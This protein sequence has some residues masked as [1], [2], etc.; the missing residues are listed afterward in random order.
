MAGAGASPVPHVLFFPFPAQGHVPPM[1]NLAELISDAGFYI[2]FVNTENIHGRFLRSS[3]PAF[4]RLAE[5]P[6]FRFRTIPDGLPEDDPRPFL[7]F[8]E[9]DKSL[10]TRSR[11]LFREVLAPAGGRDPDGWPPVSSVIADGLLPLA[12]DVAEEEDV[13][14]MLLRT[15]SACSVWAY[16]S[17]PELI[18]RGEIPFPSIKSISTNINANSKYIPNSVPTTNYVLPS[19]KRF[20][21][22]LMFYKIAGL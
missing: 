2:T 8:L 11:E 4:K 7:R 5:R 6:M 15:S 1:L 9:L 18:H 14:V 10:R 16:Y 19:L 12:M 20:K 13:P 22:I 17:I 21:K 3:S